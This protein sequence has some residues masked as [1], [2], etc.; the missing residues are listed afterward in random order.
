MIIILIIIIIIIILSVPTCNWRLL[1]V[2]NYKL[3][4]V[5]ALIKST[6]PRLDSN[7]YLYYNDPMLKT[8][9]LKYK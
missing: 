6:R 9:K 5:K 4:D 2:E 1:H 3:K 8:V 7:D